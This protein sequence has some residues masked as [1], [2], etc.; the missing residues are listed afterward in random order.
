MELGQSPRQVD[1]VRKSIFGARA[2][3][4]DVGFLQMWCKFFQS[5]M[6]SLLICLGALWLSFRC[7][8]SFDLPL[9]IQ[10]LR[11]F[12][13]TVRSTSTNS[14]PEA[15]SQLCGVWALEPSHLVP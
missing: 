7:L 15:I 9:Q 14:S 13:R 12:P 6:D 5:M 3:E 8:Y 11:K 10:Q 4:F 2:L 1:G